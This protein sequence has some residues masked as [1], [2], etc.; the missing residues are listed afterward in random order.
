MIFPLS[1]LGAVNPLGDTVGLAGEI[2][3][4]IFEMESVV[5]VAFVGRPPAMLVVIFP[6]PILGTVDP[7]GGIAVLAGETLVVIV[8][9]F[10]SVG[11]GENGA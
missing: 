10:L 11:V 2:L 4:E 3:V 7:L 9:G 6:P 8:P 5:E 1:L